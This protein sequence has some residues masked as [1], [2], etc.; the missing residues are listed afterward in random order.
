MVV[1]DILNTIIWLLTASLIAILLLCESGKDKKFVKYAPISMRSIT[2]LMTLSLLTLTYY[3]SKPNFNILEVFNR[4]A[5][6]TPW[7][8][9]VSAVWAGQAGTFMLWTWAIFVVA[10]IIS[11]KEGWGDGFVR[12][13]QIAIL[14]AGLFFLSLAVASS[15]FNPTMRGMEEIALRD[16][17]PVG[18]LLKFYEKMGKYTEDRGFIDG[19]GMNPLLMSP[20]MAV[21]PPMMFM[22]FALAVVPF[23]ACL[24]YLFQGHGDWER[25]GRT[26]ARFS[27]LFLTAAMALGGVWAYEE[28]SYGGYWNWD[29]IETASLMPW[30]TLTAFIHA[31]VEHRRKSKFKVLAPL[32]AV[33]T[34]ILII[35]ATF[36]SRSGIIKTAHGYAGSSVAPFLMAVII[37]T[38]VI[39]IILG[40]KLWK[41]SREKESKAELISQTTAIYLSILSLVGI[42]LV[43]CW[44]ITKPIFVRLLSGEELPIIKQYFNRVSYPFVVLLTLLLGFCALL[45]AVKKDALLRTTVGAIVVAILLYFLKPTGIYYFNTFFPIVIFAIAGVGYRVGMD[46]MSGKNFKTKVGVSSRHLIHLGVALILVGVIVSASFGRSHDV[47]F[48]FPGERGEIKGIGQGYSVKLLNVNVFQ[49]DKGDWV[50]EA[51]LKIYKNEYPVGEAIPRLIGYERYGYVHRVSIIRG[52]YD[53]YTIFHGVRQYHAGEKVS[54]PLTIK[55]LPLVGFI[56]AGILLA[57]MGML[58]SILSDQLL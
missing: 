18:N 49:D 1:G 2:T 20:W 9:R 17:I 48:D 39:A 31:S 45:G 35:Y 47:V 26:W 4:V 13:T 40:V 28:L 25:V 46:L 14:L 52:I 44:G 16:G 58:L 55:V 56:W 24:I 53:T 3:F 51:Y 34:I 8:Y 22:G 11:E 21:H 10:L 27:W 30:L 50:Q 23:A 37:I 15:P 12:R 38:S 41:G 42:V 32:L 7:I 57:I 29:P 43:L 6:E 5:L 19:N 54:I 33:F 36:I